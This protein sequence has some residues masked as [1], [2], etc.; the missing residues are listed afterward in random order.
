[1]ALLSLNMASLLLWA[2]CDWSKTRVQLKYIA[3]LKGNESI[4]HLDLDPPQKP[5]PPPP[6]A[7][8]PLVLSGGCG[9]CT[10]DAWQRDELLSH[11]TLCQHRDAD[12][13]WVLA[14]AV[15]RGGSSM[16]Q[17]PISGRG[18]WLRLPPRL[19]VCH[20]HRSRP[21]V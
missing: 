14:V 15:E 9:R 16:S 3:R 12:D 1:M 21:S 17:P 18:H 5:P 10:F 13:V 2:I 8:P 19:T 20:E 4:S 6:P 11:R 7:P